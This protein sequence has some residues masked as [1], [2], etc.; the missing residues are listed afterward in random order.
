M[1]YLFSSERLYFRGWKPTDL[2]DL[3]AINADDNVMQYFSQTQSKEHTRKFI[4]R[5]M[6][7]LKEE[8]L[9]Y[10]AAIEKSSEKLIGFI[11]LSMQ[12]YV[13]NRGTFVD[14]GWRLATDFWG[15]GYATEG[16]LANLNYGFESLGLKEIFAVAP[17]INGP[18]IHVMEKI[19]MKKEDEFLHPKLK[20]FENL[21][22][23]V[24]FSIKIDQFAEAKT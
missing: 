3:A 7:Q 14:V 22:R 24:L 6:V 16:A 4:E 19:G 17:K 2:E 13:P 8:G 11:G 18:S 1:N 20:G 9:C 23:C 10:F 21:E 15:K 5:M 12:D